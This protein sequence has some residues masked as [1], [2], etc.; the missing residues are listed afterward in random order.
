MWGRILGSILTSM[1]SE[2]GNDKLKEYWANATEFW[3]TGACLRARGQN[4]QHDRIP[5]TYGDSKGYLSR[6]DARVIKQKSKVRH[7]WHQRKLISI[8]A[9]CFRIQTDAHWE[10]NSKRMSEENRAFLTFV[11]ENNT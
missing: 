6:K 1:T 11:F 10:P 5:C 3:T 2:N 9:W 4:T 7:Y 8:W